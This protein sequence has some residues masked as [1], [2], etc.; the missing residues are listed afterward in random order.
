MTSQVLRARALKSL[1]AADE[2]LGTANSVLEKEQ[3]TDSRCVASLSVAP[4]IVNDLTMLAVA[5][6]LQFRMTHLPR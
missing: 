2:Q 6:R 3:I 5:H 1:H 4:E